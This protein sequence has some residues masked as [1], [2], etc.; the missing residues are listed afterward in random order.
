[1]KYLLH[2]ATRSSIEIYL[3]RLEMNESCMQTVF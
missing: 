2:I 1:L 3:A